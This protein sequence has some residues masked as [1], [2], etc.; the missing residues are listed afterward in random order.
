MGG[1]QEFC[2]GHIEALLSTRVE[3]VGDR[4][5]RGCG[6]YRRG[7]GWTDQ[8]VSC[9]SSLRYSHKTCW[10]HAEAGQLGKRK[11]RGQR[12]PEAGGQ[13]A[14]RT[15]QRKLLHAERAPPGPFE[16]GEPNPRAWLQ[17]RPFL[18]L[19]T[20]S[21]VSPEPTPPQRRGL[22]SPRPQPRQSRPHSTC[23]LSS[24]QLTTTGS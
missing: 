18:L 12:P 22:P 6:R 13:G 20:L 11:G 7:P 14:R 5:Q 2:F 21:K 9:G 15:Q 23:Q 24:A 10:P 4:R 16:K 3:M 17:G 8:V 19:A 1:T